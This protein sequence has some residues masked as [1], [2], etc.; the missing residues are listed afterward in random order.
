M[1]EDILIDNFAMRDITDTPFFIRLNARM[2]GPEGVPVGVYRRITISNLN[3]YDVG[4]RL[5]FPELG[6]GMVMDIPGHHIEHLTLS[7]ISIRGVK[8]VEHTKLKKV[9]KKEL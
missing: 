9:E 5:K 7:N 2:R 3:V 4:G 8:G 6:A 1:I